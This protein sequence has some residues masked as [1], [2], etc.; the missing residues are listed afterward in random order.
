MTASE[1][2]IWAFVEHNG[3]LLL[4]ELAQIYR[5]EMAEHF[6]TF[7]KFRIR[8]ERKDF[9][10]GE[11]FEA[12]EK[13]KDAFSIAEYSVSQTTLEQIFNTFALEGGSID[14]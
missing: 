4:G 6:F 5:V 10:I 7:F 12:I 2:Y 14:D 8:P 11:L 1:L 3:N 13:R 9:S